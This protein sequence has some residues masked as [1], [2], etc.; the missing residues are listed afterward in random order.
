MK[1]AVKKQDLKA[2]LKNLKGQRGLND[3]KIL[4]SLLRR[5]RDLG[6]IQNPNVHLVKNLIQTETV[7]TL[8]L[9]RNLRTQGR[10]KR[11]ESQIP[12]VKER[13]LIEKVILKKHQIKI[14]TERRE[15]QKKITMIQN[16]DKSL[17]SQKK[18]KHQS[19]RNS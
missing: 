7:M 19:F 16:P 2:G 4:M 3:L 9:K 17:K 8:H 12:K 13:I 6:L 10:I 18:L 5:K 11:D 14:Q 15:L 1:N